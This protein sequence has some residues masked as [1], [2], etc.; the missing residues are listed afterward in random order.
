MALTERCAYFTSPRPCW[1]GD[2]TQRSSI[3]AP[4]IFQPETD[5]DCI[6]ETSRPQSWLELPLRT[7]RSRVPFQCAVSFVL[8][9]EYALFVHPDKGHSPEPCFILEERSTPILR[10]VYDSAEIKGTLS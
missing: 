6:G 4:I 2:L 8:H 10:R 7:D 9:L 3:E 1:H 5:F